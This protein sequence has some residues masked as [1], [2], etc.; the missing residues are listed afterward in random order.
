MVCFLQWFLQAFKVLG[1]RA[2]EAKA[3]STSTVGS[4]L[5]S[6]T[7]GFAVAGTVSGLALYFQ[8]QTANEELSAMVRDVAAKQA[9][10]ERRLAALEKNR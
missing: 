7:M 6:F 9:Q 8:V 10:L 2:Q 5:R 1:F 3:G 4:R